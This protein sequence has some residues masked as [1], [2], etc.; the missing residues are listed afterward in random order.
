MTHAK[1]L[2]TK[3]L[4]SKSI[5]TCQHAGMFAK[6]KLT[7]KRFN[8]EFDTRVSTRVTNE[9][10]TITVIVSVYPRRKKINEF[11]GRTR[12]AQIRSSARSGCCSPC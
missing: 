8:A 11:G 4:K 7:D 9:F 1:K 5:C 2:A 12:H 6:K 10:T 3:A